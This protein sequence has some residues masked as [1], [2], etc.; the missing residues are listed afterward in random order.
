MAR[1]KIINKFGTLIGWNNITVPMMGR[2]LEGIQEISY[3][4]EEEHGVEHGG[5][6]YPVGKTRGKYTAKASLTLLVEEVIALQKQLPK[7]TRL[8]DLP[9]IDI[10]VQYEYSGEIYTDI[11]RNWSFTNNGREVKTGD[12]KIAVKFDGAISHIDWNV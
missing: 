7:G 9:D 3:N 6:K 8:Q 10:P 12:G 1:P 11:I 2:E 4:D 5:G